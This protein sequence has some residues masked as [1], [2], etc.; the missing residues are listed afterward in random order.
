MNERDVWKGLD[1]VS[2]VLDPMLSERVDGVLG[3]KALVE[4]RREDF[5]EAT[6]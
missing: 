6:Y 2:L 1:P 3:E 4:G 5:G